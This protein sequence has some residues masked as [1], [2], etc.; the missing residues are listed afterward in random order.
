MTLPPVPVMGSGTP[1][2]HGSNT[3]STMAKAAAMCGKQ[4][5]PAPLGG[6]S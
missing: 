5:E 3:G 6:E 4:P 2:A 1:Q